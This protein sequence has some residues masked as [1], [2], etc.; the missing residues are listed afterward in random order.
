MSDPILTEDEKGALLDGMSS[1]EIE[2]HSN[3]GP[4]YAEVTP[5]EIGPRSRIKTNSYPR[6]Q[7]L[8]RQF[9]GRMSK[10]VEALLNVDSRVSLIGTTSC[11]YN[12]ACENNEGL[13]L[14]VE[15]SPKPLD[16]S[17]FISLGAKT[18]GNLVE[19]F[20]GGQ[21]D[22]TENHNPEFFTPGEM[23]VAA[24]FGEAVLSVIAEVWAPLEKFAPEMAGTHLSSGVI[25]SVDG[26]DSIISCDFSLEFG[27]KQQ[28]FSVF[29]PVT[30][31]ASL[32]PVFE[33]QKR[34]RN[35]AEDSR[36]QRSLRSRVTDSVVKISSDVGHTRMTLRAVADL[37]PGDVINIGN[38]REGTVSARNVP[39]LAGRF[40]IHDGRYAVEAI[41]WLESEPGSPAAHS[42]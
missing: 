13:A 12:E 14:I 34:D 20:F 11:T 9:S 21:S 40:G 5:F 10:Q 4:T 22:E 1:G 2:V 24:L 23:S 36:W 19:T 38:P 7:S 29:W 39:V 32:L 41:N 18:V 31:V 6:L 17:A 28:T 33:G 35:A 16:G 37:V 15:F 42:K 27:E 8:N 25:D 26:G 30:T 3:K